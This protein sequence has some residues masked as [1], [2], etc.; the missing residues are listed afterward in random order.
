MCFIYVDRIGELR[1]LAD[2]FAEDDI[3][4]EK[5]DLPFPSSCRYVRYFR[6]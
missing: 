1:F 5:K 2:S 3:L 6:H 4:L